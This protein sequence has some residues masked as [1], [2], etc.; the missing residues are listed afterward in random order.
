MLCYVNLDIQVMLNSP[1]INSNR[2]I[3]RSNE[4]TWFS[5][6]KSKKKTTKKQRNE[7]QPT[8]QTTE[9]IQPILFF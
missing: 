5:N 3:D 1:A 8:K 2:I 4:K 6:A 7:N 9:I